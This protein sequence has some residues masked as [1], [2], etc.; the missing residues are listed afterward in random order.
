MTLEWQWNA[1]GWIGTTEINYP[2]FE[3]WQSEDSVDNCWCLNI[4]QKAD[5]EP[6]KVGE[7]RSSLAIEEFVEGFLK[8]QTQ[9]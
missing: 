5:Q 6:I 8:A 1:N 7:F 3:A 4:K 2:Q 9:E